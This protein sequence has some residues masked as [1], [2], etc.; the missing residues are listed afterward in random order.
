[1]AG[2]N[3]DIVRLLLL[4]SLILYV[5]RKYTTFKAMDCFNRIFFAA[6]EVTGINTCTKQRMST[7]ARI[8]YGLNLVV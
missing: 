5:Q 6:D 4:F 7:F 8:Y 3:H 2:T 1:M